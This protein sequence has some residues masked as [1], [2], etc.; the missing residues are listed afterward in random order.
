MF[1]NLRAV[2]WIVLVAWSMFPLGTYIISA[3]SKFPIIGTFSIFVAPAFFVIMAALSYK[4]ITQRIKFGDVLFYILVA[5]VFVF[6]TTSSVSQYVIPYAEG[7]LLI[8]L[9]TF[10]VGLLLD[11]ERLQRP[12]YIASVLCMISQFA[13]IFIYSQSSATSTLSITEENMYASYQLLPHALFVTWCTLRKFNIFGLFLSFAGF[14][15]IIAFGARGPLVCYFFFLSIYL[16]F[17]VGLIK[18]RWVR[19]A[20]IVFA[21]SIIFFLDNILV[22]LNEAL[23]SHGVNTRI[24]DLFMQDEFIQNDSTLE[25]RYLADATLKDISEHLFLGRGMAGDRYA[26]GGGYCHNF[27][28][29]IWASYGVFLGTVLILSLLVLYVKALIRGNDNEKSL[30]L[31]L[32]SSGFIKLFMSGTYIEEGLFFMAIGYSL[33]ILRQH[34][35]VR[36]KAHAIAYYSQNN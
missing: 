9:P 15:V 2:D 18:K 10:F 13:Y 24:V 12:M 32:I 26:S 11:V 34:E 23:S 3:I 8:A 27:V 22:L 21:I 19:I 17:I 29:E 14:L 1:K 7:L 20:I 30:L 4:S 5:L 25:R 16:I 31:L 28:L 36:R 33:N 6:S 35:I